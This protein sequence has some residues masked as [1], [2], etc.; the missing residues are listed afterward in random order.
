MN[1]ADQYAYDNMTPGQKAAFTRKRNLHH[2]EE[3][4][5]RKLNKAH[6]EEKEKTKRKHSK[7]PGEVIIIIII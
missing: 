1:A 2:E 3:V 4:A 5:N 6:K 7:Q